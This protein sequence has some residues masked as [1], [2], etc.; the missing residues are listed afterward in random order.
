[1]TKRIQMRA[2]IAA[3]ALVLGAVASGGAAQAASCG[4]TAYED[5]TFGPAVCAN[6]KA[7]TAVRA[8]YRQAAPAIM[9]LKENAT[10]K[11]ILAAMCSDHTANA[12]S[13]QIFDALQYQ[14]ARH[15]WPPRK[16]RRAERDIV[17]DRYC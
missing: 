4:K 15:G 7:N 11:Q 12:T 3:S 1:M 6:G 8:E 5:G 10:R 9:A 16:I 13:V 14:E 2:L 17:A